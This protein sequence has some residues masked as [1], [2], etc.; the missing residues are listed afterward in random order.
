MIDFVIETDDRYVDL[1]LRLS[2]DDKNKGFSVSIEN[3]DR[4]LTRFAEQNHYAVRH[5]YID[6]GESGYSFDRPDFDVLKEDCLLYTSTFSG[7][8]PA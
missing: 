7:Q 2:R 6:D 3:Q 1:Y 5:R 8:N 4:M